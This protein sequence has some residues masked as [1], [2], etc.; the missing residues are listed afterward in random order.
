VS[1]A[2][3]TPALVARD[4]TV[5]LVFSMNNVNLAID[6]K[7]HNLDPVHERTLSEL[8]IAGILI[9]LQAKNVMLRVTH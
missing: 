4:P 5:R 8:R 7:S 3:L 6:W 2:S 9:R 1:F